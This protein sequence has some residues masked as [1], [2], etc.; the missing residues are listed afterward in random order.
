MGKEANIKQKVLRISIT[1]NEATPEEGQINVESTEVTLAWIQS[2][3]GHP[4][5]HG[6]APVELCLFE[7]L[8]PL[9]ELVYV[10]CAHD[11]AVTFGLQKRFI[12]SRARHSLCDNLRPLRP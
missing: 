11:A 10:G 9:V 7:Q 12:L 1:S 3:C 6:R 5:S 2:A 8:I 4:R